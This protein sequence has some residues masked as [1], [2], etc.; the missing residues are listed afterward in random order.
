M[1]LEDLNKKKKKIPKKKAPSGTISPSQATT[2]PTPEV[3]TNP[4]TDATQPAATPTQNP[5]L[6]KYT[7]VYGP[8]NM[9]EVCIKIKNPNHERTFSDRMVGWG[10]IKLELKTKTFDEL[11]IIFDDLNP[12]NRQEGLDDV[13]KEYFPK[14]NLVLAKKVEESGFLPI[15]TKFA[16][17]GIPSSCRPAFWKKILNVESS[18]KEKGY[19]TKLL[20]SCKLKKLLTD[21]MIENDVKRTCDDENYFVFEDVLTEVMKAFSRDPWV[22]ENCSLKSIPLL[23]INSKGEKKTVFPPNGI[24]PFEGLTLICSPICYMFQN[25]VDVFYTFRNLYAKHLCRLHVVSSQPDSL[26]YLCKFFEDL[27]QSREP[28]LFYHLLQ[29]NIHPLSIAFHWI[30]HGFAGY[31]RVDQLL[32]LWDRVLGFSNLLLLP[33]FAASIFWLRSKWLLS[34]TSQQEIYDVF[35]DFTVIKVVPLIQMFLFTNNE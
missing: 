8:S 34:T 1:K 30:F 10:L 14:E 16:R 32:I 2:N 9:F 24:V 27:L 33:I 20:N 23:G 31:L 21:D 35:S 4:T 3:P 11:R 26:I 19:Y 25:N 18:T 17:K 12:I 22:F 15:V 29:L 5:D 13:L 6:P 7:G 28:Q